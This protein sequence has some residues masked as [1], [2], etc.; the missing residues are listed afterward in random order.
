MFQFCCHQTHGLIADRSDRDQQRRIHRVVEFLLELVR[1]V[2]ED[3][4]W[5]L[6]ARTTGEVMKTVKA[7]DLWQKIAEAAWECADPGLQ[8]DDTIN[9]WHTCPSSGRINASNPCSEY[10]FLDDT[11]CNLASLNLMKFRREDGGFEV[12][13]FRAAV[14]LFIIAQEILVDNAC[15]PTQAIAENS[16]IFRTLGLGYANLGAP[17]RLFVLTTLLPA[18]RRASAG[19]RTRA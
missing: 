3:V 13:R 18:T 11:A 17:M 19:G 15:Y 9:E 6:T 8:F 14:R 2:V 4:D 1:A 10:M 5:D 12:E 7:R 16:H